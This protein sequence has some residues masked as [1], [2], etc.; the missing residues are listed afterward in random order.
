MIESSVNDGYF[1]VSRLRLVEEI[2]AIKKYPPTFELIVLEPFPIVLEGRAQT[3]RAHK[4]SE[5]G[6][7]VCSA[8]GWVSVFVYTTHICVV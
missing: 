7:R 8:P 1:F 2:S 5:L 4:K 6:E 3:V